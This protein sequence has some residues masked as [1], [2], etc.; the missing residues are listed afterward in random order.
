MGREHRLSLIGLGA[1]ALLVL[2][3]TILVPTPDLDTIR[4]GVRGSGMLAW[5]SFLA[6]MVGATQLPVPR[7][8]WT[9]SAGVLFGPVVGSVLA[10][11]GM[12]VSVTLSLVLV[13]WIGGPAV[14]RAERSPRFRA[15]QVALED[16]GWVA[17][18][19]LRMI[20]VVPFSLLNY[21]CG[22]SRIR[23]LPCVLATIAGSA[24]LTVA[25]V[26]SSDVVVGGGEPWFLAVSVLLA[27]AGVLL[28][29]GE[30]R[31]VRARL[32]PQLTEEP[33]PVKP[34]P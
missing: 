12:A 24:P 20:P 1:L 6:L 29:A 22:L 7:T 13:R 23:L 9:V 32:A 10:L 18:L 30:W 31:R 15:L 34:S 5:A 27:A 25:V 21:A 14:R 3:A 2:V 33:A 17:V 8:V 16:R 26:A 19:G 4:H 11:A 28:T